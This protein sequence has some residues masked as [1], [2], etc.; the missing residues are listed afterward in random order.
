MQKIILIIA[1]FFFSVCFA[2]TEPDLSNRIII[3]GFSDDFTKD[4]EILTDSLGNLL[5]SPADSY[6]G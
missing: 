6:W 4:E 5:E 3:D 2:E 1:L